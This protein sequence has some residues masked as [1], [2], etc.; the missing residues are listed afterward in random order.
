MFA[1]FLNELIITEAWR[2]VINIIKKVIFV[3]LWF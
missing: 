1:L 2:E 3:A